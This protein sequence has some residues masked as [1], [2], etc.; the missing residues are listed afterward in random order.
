[1]KSLR[2]LVIIVLVLQ[3]G[4]GRDLLNAQ[5]RVHRIIDFVEVPAQWSSAGDSVCFIEF[6]EQWT[7][8]D[9]GRL[10]KEVTT[11]DYTCAREQRVLSLPQEATRIRDISYEFVLLDPHLPESGNRA[12]REPDSM[13]LP[14]RKLQSDLIELIEA[15]GSLHPRYD[16]REQLLS[17]YF[18]EE[19]VIGPD[20]GSIRKKILGITPV[21]W[22]RRQTEEGLGVDDGDTG[23]PVYYKNPLHRINLRQ[24]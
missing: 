16:P 21:I 19:W 17:V 11:Q 14:A 22:Q 2:Y 6:H 18:H 5:A 23:L 13:D 10:I 1:M 7:F 3:A 15:Y 9:K 8:M 4:R 20:T 12:F 24:P